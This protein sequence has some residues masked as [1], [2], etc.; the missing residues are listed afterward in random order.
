M[1]KYM[2]KM[3]CGHYEEVEL[4]GKITGREKEIDWL[5]KNWSCK[6]CHEEEIKLQNQLKIKIPFK[7]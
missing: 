5:K 2:V 7:T 1:S 3:N 6:K 4:F